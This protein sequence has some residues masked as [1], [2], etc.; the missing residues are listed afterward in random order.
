MKNYFFKIT[1][2][3]IDGH[4]VTLDGYKVVAHASYY[5][6][7]R[8]I[9]EVFFNSGQMVSMIEDDDLQSKFVESM[10]VDKSTIEKPSQ[11]NLVD[12]ETINGHYGLFDSNAVE[13][14]IIHKNNGK[15]Y[16]EL[17]FLSGTSF[18]VLADLLGTGVDIKIDDVDNLVNDYLYWKQKVG[19]NHSTT[20]LSVERETRP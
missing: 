17:H 6:D 14:L 7:N 19:R 4:D 15:E 9:K 3:T 5:C 20:Y 16:V 1:G 18:T 2:K 8:E 12:Y 11:S 13:F 10:Q